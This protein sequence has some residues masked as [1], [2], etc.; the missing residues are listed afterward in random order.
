MNR[1]RILSCTLLVAAL[2]ALGG[3]ADLGGSAAGPSAAPTRYTSGNAMN[4]LG[5][6]SKVNPLVPSGG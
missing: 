1:T 4:P 2:S 5:P 3:C 6:Q